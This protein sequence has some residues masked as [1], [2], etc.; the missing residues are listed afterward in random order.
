MNWRAYEDRLST[1]LRWP[2]A[3]SVSKARLDF[4]E[5]ETPDITTNLPFGRLTEMSLRLWVRAPLTSIQPSWPV[6]ISNA[7]I[8]TTGQ[9]FFKSCFC[10]R[11]MVLRFRMKVTRV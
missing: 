1:Y 3:Y 11:V 4:P 8:P 6:V 9:Q 2:S 10:L 5:P 7:P